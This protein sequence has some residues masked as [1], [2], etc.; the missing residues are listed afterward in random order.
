M[1]TI[2]FEKIKHDLLKDPRVEKAYD[3]LE[4]EYSLI[5]LMMR[6]RIDLGL[7]QEKLAQKIG[8][9]QTAISGS[10]NNLV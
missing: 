2:P 5:A 6:K 1:K 4:L 10:V 7:S 9:K 3:D 8:T